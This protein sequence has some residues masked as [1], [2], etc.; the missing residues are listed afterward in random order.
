[1]VGSV[2]DYQK[3]RQFRLLNAKKED[4][5]V[6][7]IRGGGR[8]RLLN[9]HEVVVGDVLELEPGEILPVDG[10]LISGHNVRADESSATGES[11]QIRKTSYAECV[12][13]RESGEGGKSD[14][15]VLSGGK[16]VEGSGRYLVTAVGQRSQ[17]GRL[18]MA[19]QGDPENTP[20]QLKLNRMAEI[21]AWLG[22]SAGLLLFIVLFIRFAVQLKTNADR[23]AQD[24]AQNF[25]QI[26]IIGVTVIVV[27][28]PEGLPLAVTLALAFATRR[29]TSQNL[30]VRV[31]G[32][33]ETMAN[34]TVVCTD[35]TGTL[36]TNS[37]SVVAGSIGVHLKFAARL[38]ENADRSNA[39]DDAEPSSPHP[40]PP[41]RGRKDFSLDMAD[42]NAVVKGP[43]RKLLNDSI[44]INST[45]FEGTD[46]HGNLGGFVGS[47]TETA[48]L[49]FAKAAQWSDYRAVRSEAA[50][51]QMVPFSSERK[52][53]GV[54]VKL[55]DGRH[56]LF[57]KGASE[58]LTKL[59][60]SHVVVH[61]P[62]SQSI[63]DPRDDDDS[64]NVPTVEFDEETRG[65]ISR[66]IVRR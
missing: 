3:E 36:T 22:A 54:V 38:A 49:A 33:C 66:T 39:N 45:A 52:A 51:A 15:F 16:V 61:N 14:C 65:N 60:T 24:K 57:L 53:M 11:D 55:R 30:L 26:L 6:K 42:I 5:N 59:S 56:R 47:K 58:I 10:V 44:A 50:V 13:R 46:E 37:M 23:S 7:A 20:L 43:L 48:L 1:M 29:M 21:I 40:A 31:L 17:Y 63:P 32:S 12:E 64:D 18:M 8:E 25:I 27:A 4:R 34:A 41:R 9:I 2:N 28:V 35:K 19:L 62:R